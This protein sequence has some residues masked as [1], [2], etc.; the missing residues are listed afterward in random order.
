[1][2]VPHIYTWVSNNFN[3]HTDWMLSLLYYWHQKSHQETFINLLASKR[4]ASALAH[5]VQY[6]FHFIFSTL[7]KPNINSSNRFWLMV[8]HT[9]G[10]L[11]KYPT[12]LLVDLKAGR[13]QIISLSSLPSC[14]LVYKIIPSSSVLFACLD[15]WLLDSDAIP[16]LRAC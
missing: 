7:W 15:L 11:P 6:C 10:S 9:Q 2:Y 4:R 1:M 16:V 5:I 14:A 3:L 8:I 13:S 12:L